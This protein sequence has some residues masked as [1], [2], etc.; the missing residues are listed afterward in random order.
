MSGP[1]TVPDGSLVTK[2]PSEILVYMF[3]WDAENLPAGVTIAS[4]NSTITGM[5]GDIT[6]TPASITVHTI[7]TGNRKV[8]VRVTGGAL[9]SKWRISNFIVTN[10]SPDQR[11]ERSIFLIV[12]ER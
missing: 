12:E 2:D 8:L 5:S 9:G 11:K 4:E 10:E 1:I 7:Q 6:T 3:D